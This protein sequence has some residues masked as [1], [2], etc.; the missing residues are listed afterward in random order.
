MWLPGQPVFGQLVGLRH[1]N[2]SHNRVTELDSG[3][4]ADL[5]ERLETLDL[6]ANQVGR[7][8][9][10]QFR[11]LGGLVSLPADS[12]DALV[13]VDEVG[14]LVGI[15]KRHESGRFRLRPNFRGEG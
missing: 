5:T 8:A 3:L 14:D 9:A 13:A 12:A 10:G 15:L 1:L 11:Q 7:L 2:L 6:T 4:L